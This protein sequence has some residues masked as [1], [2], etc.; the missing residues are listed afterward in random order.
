MNSVNYFRP[1][2][3]IKIHFSGAILSEVQPSV[4][5]FGQLGKLCEV[6]YFEFVKFHDVKI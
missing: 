6:D 1:V 2:L 4:R 5:N 3:Q